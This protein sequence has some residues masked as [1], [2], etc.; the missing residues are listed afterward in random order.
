M[1]TA[2]TVI[3]RIKAGTVA[4]GASGEYSD[5]PRCRRIVYIRMFGWIYNTYQEAFFIVLFVQL[6]QSLLIVSLQ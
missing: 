1:R 3:D 2:R 5:A 4:R 6:Q